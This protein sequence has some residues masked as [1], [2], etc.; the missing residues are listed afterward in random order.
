M[1]ILFFGTFDEQTHPR[2]RALQE[3]L[4]AV[5][6][7]VE[8][9]SAPLGVPTSSRVAL[10]RNPARAPLLIARIL[11]CWAHLWRAGRV[12][13]PEVVVIG[14]L[15]HF[16]VHLARRRFRKAT[17]VL[18]HMVSL[19]DTARDRGLGDRSMVTRL[20]DRI[21]R[22]ALRAADVVVVDTIEQG[23]ALPHRP[24]HLC[25]VP[26]TAPEAWAEARPTPAREPS[27]PLRVVFFGLYTPLQGAP[28][29][30]EALAQLRHRSDIEVTMIGTGQDLER[31]KEHA[32]PNPRVQWIDWVD[33]E[34]LP[35]VVASHHVCLGVFGD[36]PKA[37]RVVPNKVL[38]GASAGCAIVTSDTP[39]QRRA[40]GDA[41]CFV[42]PGDPTELAR[43]LG[44]LAEDDAEVSDRR[45]RIRRR[46]VEDLNPGRA[47]EP[48]HDLLEH[49][50]HEE[51]TMA[52]P[53]L[54]LNAWLRWDVISRELSG[55]GPLTVLELGAGQGSVASRLA[56]RGEY[57]AVEPDAESRSTTQAR[58][59]PGARV[60]ADVSELDPNETFD[61]VCAFEVIEHLEDDRG[62]VGSWARFIRPGGRM[63]LSVPAHQH[64]FAAYD[65]VAGHL[66][67][68]ERD[69]LAA[70]VTSAGL[71]VDRID[72]VGF[73]L[74]FPLEAARNVIG[75]RRLRASAVPATVAD[76]TA[77]SGRTLQPPA[78]AGGLTRAATAPFR[79]VQR[80]FHRSDLAT[81]WVLVAHR[82]TE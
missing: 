66:R 32:A 24:H 82:P 43:V 60:L 54:S 38:Q 30:G 78:W 57:T 9:V 58:L 15:G 1:Q 51:P 40:L 70:V 77:R 65:E 25:V 53:P 26:V 79:W 80:R 71:V 10:A 49:M 59:G 19:G 7:E 81:A 48:L 47:V 22:A 21:D 12:H 42:P 34:A 62:M 68:Y 50:R 56:A 16:D 61:V 72:A 35:A 6:H 3:G 5:G 11:R 63:L 14:Y 20:L 8:V 17:L 52:D 67:R 13:R 46:M 45:A 33:A 37:R 75:R 69:D 39:A 27:E 55:S 44:R 76:R 64:R 36:S 4:A 73:P 31:A 2:V 18:D 29:I 74:G 41:A 28:T 23:G